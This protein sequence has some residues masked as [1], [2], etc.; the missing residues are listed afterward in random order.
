MKA[1]KMKITVQRPSYGTTDMLID[2]VK[3]KVL[4]LADLAEKP[5]SA[6]VRLLHTSGN[7]GENRVCEVYLRMKERNL[8][9][10]HKGGSFEESAS[11]AVRR[12]LRQVREGTPGAAESQT[13]S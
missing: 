4:A 8:F 5:L 11:E 3:Q 7:A 12:L 2:Y 13:N 10:R 1:A 9:A 6:E